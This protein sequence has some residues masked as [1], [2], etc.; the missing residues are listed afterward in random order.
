MNPYKENASEILPLLKEA[1]IN[2]LNPSAHIA[3][4]YSI[5]RF[6]MPTFIPG[7]QLSRYFYQEAVAP[8]LRDH[9]ANVAHTVCLIGSGSEVLGYDTEES[10]DHDWG[11]RLQIF[12][13]DHDVQ[14]FSAQIH[15]RLSV[16]LPRTFRGFSTNFSEP[17]TEGTR[18]LTHTQEGPI[19]HGVRVTSI[20]HF[21]ASKLQTDPSRDP[22]AAEWLAFSEQAL[23]ET[24]RAAVY[25]DDLG[26]QPLLTKYS[27]YPHDIWLYLLASQWRRIDQM[28][29]LMGRSGFVGD[30]L[31]S[32]LIA[33][34]IVSDLVRLCFLM[35]RRYAPYAKWLGTAFQEL[36]SADQMTPILSAVLDSNRWEDREKHLSQAYENVAKMHNRLD[37][38]APLDPHVRQFHGRPYRVIGAQRFAEAI[39][40][41]INHPEV[42]ALPHNLGSVDQITHSVDILTRPSRRATLRHLYKQ[43]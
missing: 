2:P 27:Y 24:T 12:L 9:F 17:D 28:E 33:N 25:R 20:K 40:R 5:S 32:R 26:L 39:T 29:H 22:T 23:L 21:F 19:R 30:E 11:P 43:P 37:I 41:R 16:D 35:E 14:R 6:V 18:L 7:R 3:A 36:D 31:G 13:S 1:R 10:M 4:L 42:H 15:Q 34:R 8:I 38:T